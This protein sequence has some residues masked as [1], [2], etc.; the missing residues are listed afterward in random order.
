MVHNMVNRTNSTPGRRLRLLMSTL[1]VALVSSV[2]AASPAAADT[3]ASSS[4][5]SLS[6]SPSNPTTNDDVY[7]TVSAINCT[8]GAV[9]RIWVR[10]YSY[11]G[12]PSGGF[13]QSFF[14]S[15]TVQWRTGSDPNQGASP[16]IA[17]VTVNVGKLGVGTWYP[18]AYNMYGPNC[19]NNFTNTVQYPGGTSNGVGSAAPVISFTVTQGAVVVAG[20]A[21][22]LAATAGNSQVGLLWTAP[23]SDGGAA[24]SDYKVEYSSDSGSTWSTFADGTSTVTSA[25]VTG[26]SNG[27]AYVFRVSAVNS[28]GTGTASGTA[29]AT[30]TAPAPTT[31]TTTPPTI[32]TPAPP[33]PGS[34][35][36]PISVA[37]FVDID[38][39][40][41][42][43]D[44]V[45]IHALGITTGT[46][47]TTYSPESSV[48]RAEMA[49]F[50]VRTWKALGYSFHPS[51]T[52]FTDIGNSFASEDIGDIYNLGI[53]TGTSDTTY[54]PHAVATRAQVAAFLARSIREF[55]A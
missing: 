21:T 34:G 50:L 7:V 52:P 36:C 12:S 14:N 40:F 5:V 35:G 42:K 32:A 23:S 33:A 11:N 19:F 18:A 3:A 4:Y 29:T 24:I 48:T 51:A 1:A 55:A 38:G 20:A 13:T 39:S 54:S 44:I 15:T 6:Y 43:S 17:E 25:T 30:P 26:L 31:T 41:A 2:I 28:A 9:P 53:T 8:G 16:G 49:V 10:V 22:G 45:C 27:T 46:S 47:A 37:R